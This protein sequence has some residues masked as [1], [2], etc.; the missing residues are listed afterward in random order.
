MTSPALH[1]L[2]PRSLQAIPKG[3]ALSDEDAHFCPEVF[4]IKEGPQTYFVCCFK[5]L[6]WEGFF[7]CANNSQP[8]LLLEEK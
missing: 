1:H 2:Q 6:F 4:S 5:Y 8:L 3:K 7:G